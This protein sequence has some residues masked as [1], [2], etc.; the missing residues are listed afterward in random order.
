MSITQ[1]YHT[2]K[3]QILELHPEERIT[4][5]RN[6][7]W[8]MIGIYDSRSV[9]LSKAANRIPGEAKLVSITR[10][11]SRFLENPGIRVRAWYEPLARNWLEAQF[12]SLKEV[13]L[14]VDGTKVGSGHQLLMVCIAYRKRAI[15]IAWT[16]VKHVKGHSTA[17]K[18]L[19]LLSYV[20]SLVPAGTTVFLVGDTEFG[21]VEVQKQLETWRWHYVLR[22]K[23]STLIWTE[24]N[25]AW[26][27]FSDT[28]ERAGQSYWLGKGF[29]T[30]SKIQPVQLCVHWKIG[31]KEPWF[32]AT[33]LPDK[34]LALTF[35]NR[36]M[37]VEEMFGDLKGHGFDLEAS[38]LRSFLKLSRL[39]LIVVFLYLWAIATGTQVIHRGLRHLVDRN[40]RRDLS[41]FQIGLRYIQRQRTNASSVPVLTRYY[42]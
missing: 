2:W 23:G 9:T 11:F 3:R 35:Y 32:L 30:Y 40:D 42:R 20:K 25:Q 24:A 1:L 5:V 4:R 12:T 14:I 38:M 21:A 10:R 7:A 39:T 34:R 8:M 29:L 18:Q 37:W 17:H 36:R 28:V 16:W 6:F 13:R 41:I 22:Q 27:P 15:P 31:E 33:N 26:I 19:A